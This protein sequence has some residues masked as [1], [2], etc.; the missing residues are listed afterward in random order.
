VSRR[1][2]RRRTR[3]WQPPPPRK[4][5]PM[6]PTRL[7]DRPW[8]RQLRP[9]A[10][11]RA[12]RHPPTRRTPL[13]RNKVRKWRHYSRNAA[14][15]GTDLP[16][17]SHLSPPLSG[18]LSWRP[19]ESQAA[20]F[21]ICAI[22]EPFPWPPATD[23][24]RHPWRSL[25][26]RTCCAG[27]VANGW[28]KLDLGSRYRWARTLCFALRPFGS[29]GTCVAKDLALSVLRGARRAEWDRSYNPSGAGKLHLLNWS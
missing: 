16:Q 27:W 20:I 18:S 24:R 12:P 6:T 10:P 2:R 9:K 23:F 19:G 14:A 25:G 3:R 15:S 7:P 8:R 21:I 5:P 22:S 4:L 13:W 28:W 17:G 11:L 26:A 1:L 29:T